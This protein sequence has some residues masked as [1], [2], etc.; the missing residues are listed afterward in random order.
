[1]SRVSLRTFA[2]LASAALL[3]G[4]FAAAPADAA[5]K[6]KKKPLTCDTFTPGVEDAAE[7]EV[8]KVTP[9]ASEA[10]PLVIEFEHPGSIP[11]APD[12]QYFNFQIHSGKP[13]TGLWIKSEF[14]ER[15]DLDLYLYN[16]AGEEVALSGG[17]NTVPEA[18]DSDGN[19]TT[20]SEQIPGYPVGQC[21]G[22]TLGSSAYLTSGTDVK[23]TV[24]LGE[25]TEDYS[26]P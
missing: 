21:E 7:A 20:N 15:H 24:W 23:L 17:F 2:T 8:V 18:H 16:E 10:K 14:E 22:Y 4:A 1:M 13:G 9:A 6:K 26:K 11:V 3:V 12:K 25:A 19:A 5:K